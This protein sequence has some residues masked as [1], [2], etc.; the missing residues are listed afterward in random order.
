MKAK[1][2]ELTKAHA[3]LVH[4][5]CEMKNEILLLRRELVDFEAKTYV[6]YKKALEDS[7]LIR[8]VL[9][10]GIT[11]E[12]T[13]TRNEQMHTIPCRYTKFIFRCSK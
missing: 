12:E 6:S 7:I 2:S 10:F 3:R 9:E 5:N 8:Y 4:E 13:S 11:I 1:N